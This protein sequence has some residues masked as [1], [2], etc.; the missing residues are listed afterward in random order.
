MSGRRIS[1]VRFGY[2]FT[3]AGLLIQSYLIDPIFLSI[4]ND[5][6]HSIASAKVPG[7]YETIV[8]QALPRLTASIG[9]AN[10]NESWVASSALELLGSV[11]R[12]AP[13]AGLGE[14]FFAAI[15]PCVF[16]CLKVAED[17]D[18]LQVRARTFFPDRPAQS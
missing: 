7:V 2:A 14:G 17:R 8:K 5:V 16:D 12:G 6:L 4:L 18:V 15:A 13:E 11:T 3:S 9:N 10:P 1:R